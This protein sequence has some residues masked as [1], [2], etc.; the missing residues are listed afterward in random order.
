MGQFTASPKSIDVT[1][2]EGSYTVE[3]TSNINCVTLSDT[4]YV[5]ELNTVEIDLGEDI[6]ICRGDSILI[7]TLISGGLGELTY[8]WTPE[9]YLSSIDS[10][11]T[12]AFPDS[13]TVYQ[14]SVSDTAGNTE[15][16][17]ITIYVSEVPEFE[18]AGA[19]SVNDS[20]E[21]IY[22]IINKRNSDSLSWGIINGE[23]IEEFEDSVLVSWYD[24]SSGIIFADAYNANGCS[25]TDSLRVIIGEKFRFE[26]S[27]SSA[28]DTLC[29]GD[30]A[31]ISPDKDYSEYYYSDGTFTKHDTVRK[32]GEYFLIVKDENGMFGISDTITIEF[33]QKPSTFING[34]QFCRQDSTYKYVVPN[35][36]NVFYNIG[37]TG[38][39]LIDSTENEYYARW[40][41]GTSGKIRLIAEN[42]TGCKDTASLNIFVGNFE[43]PD[44][45]GF[46]DKGN[47]IE[48][49]L[50]FCDGKWIVLDAGKGY[51]EYLWQDSSD[52]RYLQV[53]ES[54]LYWV[55]TTDIVGNTHYS[56]TLEINVLQ[57]PPRPQITIL[58]SRIR[59]NTIATAYQWYRNGLIMPGITERI[60]EPE[61]NGYYEV[62]ITSTNGCKNI[63]DRI[64]FDNTDVHEFS[65]PFIF[66]IF[67]NPVRN[68]ISINCPQS[69]N[70][71]ISIYNALGVLVL[72]TEFTGSSH[73]MATDGLAAGIYFILISDGSN[74][75]RMSVSIIK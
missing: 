37:V 36:E 57:N 44:I 26:I 25:Y 55:V 9:L 15:S 45:E 8:E 69:G 58:G 28:N 49:D 73:Q 1:V 41:P 10:S 64:Y 72:N 40:G 19:A 67:P 13:T 71:D 50:A 20:T 53:S 34:E 29:E 74:V 59:C 54:G 22:R 33:I 27:L 68:L 5:N 12:Y 46:D 47:K 14:L 70:Y 21:T 6:S 2:G 23:I 38:G 35:E 52:A 60:I 51:S 32:S 63:S 61:E 17:N 7:G 30:F 16:D 65:D 39:I 42:I 48:G 18:I 43:E 4:F 31:V 56:D 75:F 24:I 11:H 66:E 3:V 62:E